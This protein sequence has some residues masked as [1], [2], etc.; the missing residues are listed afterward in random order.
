MS[1]EKLETMLMQTL[2]GQTKSIMLFSE[3]AYS[4][5]QCKSFSRIGDQESAI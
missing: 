3:M 5:R 1:Q 4:G 2:G